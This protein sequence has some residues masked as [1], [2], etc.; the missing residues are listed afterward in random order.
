[1]DD[2]LIANASIVINASRTRVWHALV[3]PIAIK[4]Y[5]F[6]TDVESDWLEGGPILWKGEWQGKPYEDKGVIRRLLQ[7]RTLE[8]SHY[9]P[10]SELPDQPSSYHI[11]TIQ[12]SDD[13]SQTRVSLSQ[14]G[15]LTEDER[16]HSAKNWLMMLTSLK[17][18]LEA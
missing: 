4:K 12:L 11:V 15:N 16:D 1:V 10:L 18:L 3:D 7:E 17:K 8:Y 14:D 5:M 2:S 6:G 13:G 9:S